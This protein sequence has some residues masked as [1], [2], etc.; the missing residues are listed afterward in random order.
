MS[1]AT[2]VQTRK[3]RQA[4]R[5]GCGLCLLVVA[6][7]LHAAAIPAG[8]ADAQ[9]PPVA[10]HAGAL[11]SLK[12]RALAL[13][14]HFLKPNDPGYASLLDPP[15]Y[16]LRALGEKYGIHIAQPDPGYVYLDVLRKI[17]EDSVGPALQ[18]TTLEQSEAHD[19]AWQPNGLQ[20][21]S[22]PE[23]NTLREVRFVPQL[24]V[25]VNEV[26]KVPGQLQFGMTYRSWDC[27]DAG[28][29]P[30]VH[31]VPQMSLRWTYR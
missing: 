28:A 4:A 23:R 16:D 18:A 5:N 13:L 26:V 30:D 8:S 11:A 9:P 3:R 21:L 24:I 15:R 25:N 10:V 27:P 1:V 6:L 12:Q 14:P 17:S 19:R 31:P 22:K 20:D 29:L 7:P 2:A